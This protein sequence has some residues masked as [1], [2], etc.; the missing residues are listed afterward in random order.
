MGTSGSMHLRGRHNHDWVSQPGSLD[1][2][3]PLGEIHF[4][5]F[6]FHE[7]RNDFDD[8]GVPHF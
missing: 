7:F 4:F 3:D 5:L 8:F 6:F 2:L 1:G